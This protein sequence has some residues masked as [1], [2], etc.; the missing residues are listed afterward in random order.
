MIILAM[1]QRHLGH[2]NAA[3]ATTRSLLRAGL[4]S[5]ARTLPEVHARKCIDRGEMVSLL[6]LIEGAQAAPLIEQVEVAPDIEEID[7]D[8]L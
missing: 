5:K 7:G 8:F 2:K 1:A 3:Q 4:D 6:R